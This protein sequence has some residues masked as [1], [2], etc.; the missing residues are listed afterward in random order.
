MKY[1]RKKNHLMII[2]III[3]QK[4]FIL[5]LYIEYILVL[6]I[7]YDCVVYME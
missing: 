7:F 3:D 4:I 1:I 6:D 5:C 2:M